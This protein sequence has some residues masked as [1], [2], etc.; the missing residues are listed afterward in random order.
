MVK[1]AII[2]ICGVQNYGDST[3]TVRQKFLGTFE[4]RDVEYTLHYS[5]SKAQRVTLRVMKEKPRLELVRNRSAL[6]I[7]PG[8]RY[9]CEYETEAGAAV[10]GI[11]GTSVRAEIGAEKGTVYFAYK[12]DT[13]GEHLSKNEVTVNFRFKA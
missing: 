6:I 9:I 12:I 13:N 4:E 1:K 5:E 3:D 11:S 7:D 2:E 8:K 10:L